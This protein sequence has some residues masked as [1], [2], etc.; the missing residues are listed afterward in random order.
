M[1]SAGSAGILPAM[2]AKA[3]T[4]AP[5]IPNAGTQ[6][7]ERAAH[8]LQAGCLRSRLQ[9]HIFKRERLA[10]D[11]RGWRRDPARD[12]AGLGYWMHQAANIFPVLGT[13]QPIAFSPLEFFFRD[14]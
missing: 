7:N 6:E 2:S 9:P 3:R 13:W 5:T 1:V 11:S 12:F 4:I 10:F 8:A 14:Q